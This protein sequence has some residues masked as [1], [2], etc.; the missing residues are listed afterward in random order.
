MTKNGVENACHQFLGAI[1]PKMAR[2]FDYYVRPLV[3]RMRRD[4]YPPYSPSNPYPCLLNHVVAPMFRWVGG[5][6]GVRAS[7]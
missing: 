7:S 4:W 5:G 6:G 3:K 2:T 1:A